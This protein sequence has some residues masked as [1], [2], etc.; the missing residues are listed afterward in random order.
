MRPASTKQPDPRRT[1]T[2]E[3]ALISLLADGFEILLS[4]ESVAAVSWEQVRTI[5]AY[6]RFIGERSNLCLAFLVPDTAWGKEDQVV[7]HDAV[8]GWEEVAS[9]LPAQFPSMDGAWREKA[10]YDRTSHVSLGGIVPTYTM[11]IV[12]VWPLIEELR[13]NK[14][15]ERTRA[16]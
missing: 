10:S 7:V 1:L 2:P 14:S 16:K 6:T 13:P 11:N 4:E 5:F 9:R 8:P 3:G 12:Q 15:L